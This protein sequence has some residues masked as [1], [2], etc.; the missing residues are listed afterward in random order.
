MRRR[1]QDDASSVSSTSSLLEPEH[2]QKSARQQ[3]TNVSDDPSNYP[4][5]DQIS[6]ESIIAKYR[7]LDVRVAE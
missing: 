5:L 1:R 7:E 3:Y 6:Q 2:I 4:S